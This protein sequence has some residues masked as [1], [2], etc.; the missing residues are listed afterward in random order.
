VRLIHYSD[1]HLTVVNSASQRSGRPKIVGDK[2]N[3]LWVS[4]IGEDDWPSWCEREDF[5]LGRLTHPTE[6]VMRTDATLLVVAGEAAL[7]E[8]DRQYGVPHPLVC[9]DSYS[10]RRVIDWRSV[11]DKYQ[12]VVIAPWV[13]TFRLDIDMMW[14]YGWDCASGVIWDAGSVKELRPLPVRSR[15]A[16]R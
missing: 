10:G 8:F 14:Y 16:V 1:K 11:A 3:G 7:Q 4:P 12:G 15:S 2:P 13:C 6:V 9:M 5:G